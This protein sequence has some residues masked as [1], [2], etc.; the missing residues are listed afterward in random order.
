MILRL[1]GAQN[2][3]I[4]SPALKSLLSSIPQQMS[5]NRCITAAKCHVF[6]CLFCFV[7]ADKQV[8][9]QDF[10]LSLF[11]KKVSACA[12]ERVWLL[13]HSSRTTLYRLIFFK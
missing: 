11:L 13:D 2:S 4:N 6:V 1:I 7:Y 10:D 5:T 9:V 12:I 8:Q 3:P